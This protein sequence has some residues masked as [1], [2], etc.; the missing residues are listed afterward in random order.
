MT[1][2]H[3]AQAEARK[4]PLLKDGDLFDR[5]K[6]FRLRWQEN[7][8]LTYLGKALVDAVVEI[9]VLRRVVAGGKAIPSDWLRA[10]EGLPAEPWEASAQQGVPGYGIVA[11]VFGGDERRS[12]ACIEMTT[13]ESA[14]TRLAEWIARCSP[15][16]IRALVDQLEEAARARDE[17]RQ[18]AQDVAWQ[19]SKLKERVAAEAV[20]MFP[21]MEGPPVP[22]SLIAPYEAQA[23]TNHGQSLKQLAGRGGL[24]MCEAMAVMS[25]T[26]YRDRPIDKPTVE[27][28]LDF[29]AK[30]SA[31]ANDRASPPAR[32]AGVK[33]KALE[34]SEHAPPDGKDCFYDHV[35]AVTPFGTYSIEW[36]G[37][38]AH[39]P[40]TVFFH[41]G[42]ETVVANETT[43]D[44]AKTAAQAD[45]ETRILSALLPSSTEAQAGSAKDS[46]LAQAMAALDGIYTYCNDTLSGRADGGPD[47]RAWQR[48][49]VIHARNLARPFARPEIEAAI[50]REKEA[51]AN[52]K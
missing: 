48:E 28:W 3:P 29:I 11:Q 1:T 34:W 19:N 31:R 43:L 26:L 22:W 13:D 41:G 10:M 8:D 18:Y 33:V 23:R 15:S 50:R 37:W 6:Q 14:A 27:D 25:S 40:R 9:E 52:E 38:K 42:E 2:T 4:A 20:A 32:G 45:Y 5:L 49:A 35:M 21:I 39:D 47:D 24:N 30:R 12:L 17:A 16:G 46:E 44:E 51:S 7:G 36:K